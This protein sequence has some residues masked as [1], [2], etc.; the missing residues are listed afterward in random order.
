MATAE[1]ESGDN[2]VW[3]ANCWHL[4]NS[5]DGNLRE[6]TFKSRSCFPPTE[7]V[8]TS[9]AEYADE[10]SRLR[11]LRAAVVTR[12]HRWA[13]GC[14]CRRQTLDIQQETWTL[15]WCTDVSEQAAGVHSPPEWMNAFNNDSLHINETT[16]ASHI[17]KR[18]TI[19][20][21]QT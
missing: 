16:F 20:F 13:D 1:N 11:R 10:I 19:A 17:I 21:S 18:F 14:R 9:V 2:V 12:L 4:L 8:Y 7:P 15:P 6:G 5:R 3:P